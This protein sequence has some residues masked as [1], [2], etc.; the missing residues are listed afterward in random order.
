MRLARQAC[1]TMMLAALAGGEKPRPT[2][3][4]LS[5]EAGLTPSH[6]H[7]VFKKVVGITPGKYARDLMEGKTVHRNML[8][9]PGGRPWP[10]KEGE[11]PQQHLPSSGLDAAMNPPAVPVQGLGL[12][13]Q[14]PGHE[15]NTAGINW[16]EF[17]LMLAATT[18][19]TRVQM[20]YLTGNHTHSGGSN[21]AFCFS[22]ATDHNNLAGD[23]SQVVVDGSLLS[24][25]SQTEHQLGFPDFLHHN[26]TAVDFA[27]FDSSAFDS[28][29][30]TTRPTSVPSSQ[31]SLSPSGSPQLFD[32]LPDSPLLF[33]EVDWLERSGLYPGY[34]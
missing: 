19:G 18:G 30:L 32:S 21:G 31:Q 25:N 17:D 1:E 8:P 2:L 16:N 4:D 29:G 15:P 12:S 26:D 14:P 7:R 20:D 11:T 33:E 13:S 10:P 22:G 28:P 9:G 23:P 5:S 34:A 27:A 6:F 24:L 3:Q